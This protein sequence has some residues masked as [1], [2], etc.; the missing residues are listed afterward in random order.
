MDDEDEV[1]MWR[2]GANSH[3]RMMNLSL[4]VTFGTDLDPFEVL[5]ADMH[6]TVIVLRKVVSPTKVYSQ[7]HMNRRPDLARRKPKETP[8]LCIFASL[9]PFR[10]SGLSINPSSRRKVS[11]MYHPSAPT[12]KL[13]LRLFHLHHSS[14]R[15]LRLKQAV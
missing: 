7:N 8:T 15:R 13:W 11:S 5:Y 6:V 4:T 3:D 14:Q 10:P 9:H 1:G 2:C 12:P